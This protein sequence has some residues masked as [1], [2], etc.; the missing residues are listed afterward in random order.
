[1]LSRDKRGIRIAIGSNRPDDVFV[2]DDDPDGPPSITTKDPLSLLTDDHWQCALKKF[3]PRKKDI[4][5]MKRSWSLNQN[6]IELDD[7]RSQMCYRYLE[8][9]IICRLKY[10][11]KQKAGVKQLPWVQPFEH[12]SSPNHLMLASGTGGGK[13]WL[14]NQLLTTKIDGR[15]AFHGRDCCMFVMDPEDASLEDARKMFKKNGKLTIVDVV[16][17]R[18]AGPGAIKL[19]DLPAGCVLVVDDVLS[20]LPKA[21]PAYRAVHDLVTEAI[22]RGRHHKGS[23][24]TANKA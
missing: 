23:G 12:N 13:G 2:V 3:R 14:L 21:D 7:Q 8:D 17:L 24:D 22:V 10:E 9:C 4:A 15:N 5:A 1:M 11:H 6:S 19:E 18:A 16:K 20:A